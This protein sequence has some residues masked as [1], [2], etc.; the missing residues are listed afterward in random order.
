M[1]NKTNVI[2]FYLYQNK[3]IQED[4]MK[5]YVLCASLEE[6]SIKTL[7]KLKR[8]LDLTD[9]KVHFVTVIEIQ[10]YNS[11]LSAYVYPVESQY[12]EIES[13]AVA[14]QKNLAK[15]LGVP[16]AQATFKCFFDHSPEAKVKDYLE[17]VNADLV[18]TATRGRHGIAGFFSSSFTDFLCKYSPCD[19]LVL[20][21]SK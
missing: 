1:N 19:I 8:D 2:L 17:K 16:E 21:P 4:P 13:S 20:R 3:R 18:V 10:V 6:D 5:N 12:A 11:E 14:I 9:A 15:T 7:A